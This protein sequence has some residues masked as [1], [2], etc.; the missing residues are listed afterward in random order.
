MLAAGLCSWSWPHRQPLSPAAQGWKV[1]SP[2][3]RR[4]EVGGREKAGRRR[5]R[6]NRMGGRQWEARGL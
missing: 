4:M 5:R 2:V 3:W 1:N 6:R